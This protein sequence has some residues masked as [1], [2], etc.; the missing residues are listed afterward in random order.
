M[1]PPAPSTQSTKR[2]A[3]RPRVRRLGPGRYL[4]ESASRPGVGHPVT[5]DRCNCTGCAYR[6]TCRHIALVRTIEAPMQAWYSQAT[7]AGSVAA[8]MS[9]HVDTARDEAARRLDSA[10][11]ALT[12][13][14]PRDDSYAVLLRQ[15]DRLERQVAA[16][17][18]AALRAA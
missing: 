8:A 4:V 12:D 7:A 1:A 18:T 6:G 13:V 16:V 2:T 10:R 14:D 5:L 11:R 15:V 3:F 17:E 9:A